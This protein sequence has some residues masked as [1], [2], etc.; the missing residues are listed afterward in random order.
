MSTQSEAPNG[1]TT[2]IEQ[3]PEAARRAEFISG[4]RE[5]ADFLTVHPE[6]EFSPMFGSATALWYCKNTEEL[7]DAARTLGRADKQTSDSFLNLDRQFGPHSIR[8]YASHERVCERVVVRTETV[9]REEPDP[10]A[11]K[12]VPTVTV[13]EEREIVEWRCPDSILAGVES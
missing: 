7:A 10:E 2:T 6:I 3:S 4:L 9:T 5:L 8:A 1:S 11:L 13:T 12:N